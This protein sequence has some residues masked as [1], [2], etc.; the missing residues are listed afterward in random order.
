MTTRLQSSEK[1]KDI[2]CVVWDLDNTVWEGVLLEGG[3]KTLRPHIREILA[4]LDRRGILHSIASRNHHETALQRLAHFGIDHYFLVPEINWNA[5]SSSIQRIQ[6]ALNL[7]I[8]SFMFVDDQAYELAEVGESLPQVTCFDAANY[9][10]LPGLDMLTPRFV[11]DEA[12]KR[13]QLYQQQLQREQAQADYQGP[14]EAFLASLDMNFTIHPA[15]EHDLERAEEL[16]VRTNQLNATGVTYSFEQLNHYRSQPDYQLLV[17]QL[18]DRFG[19]YGKIGLALLE[20]CSDHFYVR[21]LLMSCRVMSRGVGSILLTHLM[22]LS[23]AGNKPLR[24]DF[25]KTGR[26]RMMLVTYRFAGFKQVASKADGSLV[27][28][29]D[30]S[31]INPFPQHVSVNIL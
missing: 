2:K 29:H 24:A 18:S 17:C 8:D 23:R 31:N 26:N 6:Q 21:L 11:T 30:L 15:Q 5:K 4:S 10:D 28:E 25:I 9:L 22:N 20:E 12:P 7:G 3:A 19:D 16:T 27:L 13:R 1:T 14:T